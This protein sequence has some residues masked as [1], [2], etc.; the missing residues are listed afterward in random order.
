MTMP[1]VDGVL[2]VEGKMLQGVWLRGVYLDC[3]KLGELG[4]DVCHWRFCCAQAASRAEKGAHLAESFI[5]GPVHDG[6]EPF[7]REE[8]RKFF[9]RDALCWKATQ[10]R[11][12]HQ[13]DPD[14]RVRQALVDGTEQRHTQA[15]VFLAEPNRN[16][17]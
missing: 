11:W 9:V 6:N 2:R 5:C 1:R 12:G 13:N 17:A 16:A 4:R 15:N 8:C 14:S 7:T 3:D 10:Q